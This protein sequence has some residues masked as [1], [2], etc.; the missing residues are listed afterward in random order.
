MTRD[1]GSASLELVLLTPVLLALL[2]LVV[3]AGRYGAAR[4]DVDAAGRDAAAPAS[5]ER[6]VP[7]AARTPPERPPAAASPTET[8]SAPDFD[9]SVSTST[10]SAPAVPCRRP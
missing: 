7:A 10:T 2:L 1:R 4:S 6:S 5:L 8:S 9:I 3:T